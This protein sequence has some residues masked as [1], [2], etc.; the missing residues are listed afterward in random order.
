MKLAAVTTAEEIDCI[1]RLAETC[2]KHHYIPIIG[3]AQ[4]DYMLRQYQSTESIREQIAAGRKYAIIRESDGEPLGYLGYDLCEEHLFLSK[5]YVLPSTQ[6][7]GVGK[8][9]LDKLCQRYPECRIRLTV[10]KQNHSAIKFYAQN[11]F[12]MSGPV[13]TDIG[14]GFVMDDWKM[15][16]KRCRAHTPPA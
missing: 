16:K 13:V 2:W 8:W 6:R 4:V 14:H 10:N 1:A 11:D 5:L 7:R 12:A 9:A 15:E 3:E